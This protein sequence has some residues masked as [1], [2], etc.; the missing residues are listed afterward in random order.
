M[1]LLALENAAFAE[2]LIGMAFLAFVLFLVMDPQFVCTDEI[3]IID[4]EMA[5]MVVRTTTELLLIGTN[6]GM[7][8]VLTAFNA[9]PTEILEFGCLHSFD[10]AQT[11]IAFIGGERREQGLTGLIT[12]RNVFIASWLFDL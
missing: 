1:S 8:F 11:D 3:I 4:L 9:S 7:A 12:G 10:T 2:T 5:F 6:Y